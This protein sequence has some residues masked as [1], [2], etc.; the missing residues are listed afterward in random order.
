MENNKDNLIYLDKDGNAWIQKHTIGDYHPDNAEFFS[1]I[2]DK[3]NKLWKNEINQ[4]DNNQM[5]VLNSQSLS[6]AIENVESLNIKNYY[7][8]INVNLLNFRVIPKHIERAIYT[9]GLCHYNHSEAYKT[10]E[11]PSDNKS[12]AME[13]GKKLLNPNTTE[14]I[15]Y[16]SVRHNPEYDEYYSKK[17]SFKDKFHKHD[18][19]CCKYLGSE[20]L[21]DETFDYYFCEQKSLNMPTVISRF[22]NDGDYYSGLLSAK[23]RAEKYMKDNSLNNIYDAITKIRNNNDIN[24]DGLIEAAYRAIQQGHLNQNLEYISPAIKKKI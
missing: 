5:L 9:I 18:C 3:T 14:H 6:I 11:V 23:I 15:S 16:V 7:K 2:P 1:T 19:D 8:Y 4:Q 10:I 17:P 20:K 22:G 24:N 13:K 12:K 21:K